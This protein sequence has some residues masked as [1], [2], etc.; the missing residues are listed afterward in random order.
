M[1][2]KDVISKLPRQGFILLFCLISI[3]EKLK[4]KTK[5]CIQWLINLSFMYLR[6][7]Q[8]FIWFGLCV[9][10]EGGVFDWDGLKLL[11]VLEARRIAFVWLWWYLLRFFSVFCFAFCFISQLW[12]CPVLNLLSILFQ[13]YYNSILSYL[14]SRV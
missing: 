13:V 2:C 12:R 4:K 10:V 11:Q 3:M 7:G 5:P 14:F 8:S 6:N 9:H 1:F